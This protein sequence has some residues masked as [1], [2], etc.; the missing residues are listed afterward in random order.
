MQDPE[1]S[2]TDETEAGGDPPAVAPPPREP[3]FNIPPMAMILLATM[4]AVMGC[5]WILSPDADLAFVLALAVI[6]ARLAGFASELP[7]GTISIYTQFTTHMFVHAD[8]MHLAFNS[9]SLLAFAGVLEKRLG[10]A[11]LLIMFLLC[12]FAG[13]AAFVAL[14]YGLLAPMIGAS[15]AVAGLMGGAMRLFFSSIEHSGG[16]RQLNEAPLSVPLAP[17]SMALR[18]RRLQVVTAAF[19]IMNVAAMIGFGDINTGGNIAW[20]AHIGGYFAGLLFFSFF[21]A[22]PRHEIL[23]D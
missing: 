23:P 11:R 16:L 12:G 4:L 13:A 7:G 19:V 17:L 18:D 22:A 15:G 5:R 3:I 2:K 21:D 6:P 1:M 10:S 20:E 8:A 9:A 14:N